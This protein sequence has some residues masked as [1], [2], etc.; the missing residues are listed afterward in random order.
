MKWINSIYLRN[1]L[2]Y[3]LLGIAALYIVSFF[4]HFLYP[5]ISM[6]FG[7]FAVILFLDFTLLFFIKPSV[8]TERIYPERFS[9]G[10]ENFLEIKV[11]NQYKFKVNI[12]LIE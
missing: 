10:D 6:I 1:E 4:F 3:A 9:N 8:I 7:I 12:R 2:F 11:K 5:I